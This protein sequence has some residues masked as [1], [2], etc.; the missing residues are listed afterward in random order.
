MVV[1]DPIVK[2]ENLG[3]LESWKPE[4]EGSGYGL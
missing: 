4:K 3:N 1:G 2:Q